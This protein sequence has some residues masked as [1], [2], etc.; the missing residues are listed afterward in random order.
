MFFKSDT[1]CP[2]KLIINNSD[3]ENV[4]NDDEKPEKPIIVNSK[5]HLK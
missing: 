1:S 4:N 5:L 2:N 3:I